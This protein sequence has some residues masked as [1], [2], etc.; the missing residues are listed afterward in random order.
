MR[1]MAPSQFHNINIDIKYKG[2][3]VGKEFFA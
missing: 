1:V 2:R 3:T